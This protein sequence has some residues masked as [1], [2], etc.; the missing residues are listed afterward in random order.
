MGHASMTVVTSEGPRAALPPSTGSATLNSAPVPAADQLVTAAKT[1]QDVAAFYH[2]QTIDSQD[3]AV[4]WSR[5]PE[6]FKEYPGARTI[7]LPADFARS[8]ESTAAAVDGARRPVVALAPKPVSLRELSTI[9]Q[10][11]DGLTGKARTRKGLAPIFTRAAP[12][13]GALYP[14]LVYVVARDVEGLEPGIYHYDVKAPALQRVSAAGPAD[15]LESLAT[16]SSSPQLLRGAS[17]ALVFTTD[18]YRSS[19][20][21][22]AR[23][24]RF[25]LLDAG[26]MAENAILAAEYE[27]LATR[28]LGRFDDRRVNALLGLDA[29]R[30]AALLILPFG[31]RAPGSSAGAAATE[32]PFVSAPAE[33]RSPDVP[34]LILLAHGRTMLA[35]SATPGTTVAPFPAPPPLAVR[36]GDA[37]VALPRAEMP[38]DDLFATIEKRRSA[39]HWT[40]AGMTLQ[41]LSTV[42]ETSLGTA[43]GPEPSTENHG[44]LREYVVAMRVQDL[45]PGVYAYDPAGPALR[46]LKAGQLKSAMYSAGL[47]QDCVGDA[48]AVIVHTADAARLPYPDGSRGYRYANLDAGMAGERLYLSTVAL[49]LGTTGV[50]SFE[51]DEV[52]ALLGTGREELVLYLSA[53]GAVP[54]KDDD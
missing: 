42:L 6:A 5:R 3:V 32:W 40:T 39:R 13:A 30:E 54:E 17:F 24:Y 19:F 49:G 2:R 21:Y 8:K 22:G 9:L 29:S 41:Q 47:L 38:A 45:A 50:G 44:A 12:S 28:P 11:T 1:T 4:D 20:K 48:S 7:P 53:I 36:S 27:G 25:G 46:R 35:T 37:T 10:M 16:M 43:A 18:Y 23:S 14:T 15:D 51:D 31:E 26:H 33:L 52:G 34:T